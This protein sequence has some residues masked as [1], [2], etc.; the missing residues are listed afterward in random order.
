MVRQAGGRNLATHKGY[1]T[2]STEALT[3]LN[4]DVVVMAD[5]SLADEA[6]RAALIRQNPG[7]A[8]TRAVHDGRLISLDPTLLVGGLGPRI[9]DGLALLSAAF[10]PS[11]QP[12]ISEG[13]P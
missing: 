10:Y 2:L 12:L 4:P 11:A 7:L 5:R 3:A 1:K 13:R 6:A 8:A 9:P